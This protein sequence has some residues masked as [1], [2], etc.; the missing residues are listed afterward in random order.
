MSS[1]AVRLALQQRKMDS[2]DVPSQF[3]QLDSNDDCCDDV[4]YCANERVSD[5]QVPLVGRA[6][7]QKEIN[8]RTITTNA[9]SPMAIVPVLDGV[10]IFIVNE[11]TFEQIRFESNHLFLSQLRDYKPNRNDHTINMNENSNR[12]PNKNEIRSDPIK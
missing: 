5:T 12:F 8:K 7:I 4:F 1:D 10:F 9:L 11:G 6:N 2:D 3:W